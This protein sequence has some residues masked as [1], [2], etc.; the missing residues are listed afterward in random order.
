M[1]NVLISGISGQVGSYLAEYLLSLGNINVIGMMRRLS[2]SGVERIDHILKNITLVQGDLTD[3]CS[4]DAIMKKYRPDYTF[5]LA[6]QSH[7]HVSWQQPELTANVTG[8]GVLRLL[9]A[10]RKYAPHTIFYQAS[11]S[12]MF[13]KVLETPQKE[14]TPFY[15]RSPYGCA[16]VFAFETVRVYRESYNMM[17]MNGIMFNSESPR[18]SDEFVTRKITKAAVNIKAG[19]QTFL[20][21][22]NVDAKRDW[23]HVKDAVRAIWLI[24]NQGHAPHLLKDYLFSSGE[25]HSIRE[26]L[27]VAFSYIGLDWHQYV[28]VDP[29]FV[30]PAEVDLLLGDPSAIK[31]DLGWKS[32]IG[33]EM[34][35]HDMMN[36]D[37]SLTMDG[38]TSKDL[39]EKEYAKGKRT[40]EYAI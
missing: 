4:L 35:V 15:P 1:K 16:K 10:A 21:L 30:R 40:I 31:A 24:A 8:L 9:E 12:E 2:H 14:T 28:V 33:F 23:M 18:R 19:N 26:F 7:V 25:T 11:S 5:N 17:A 3:Q 29:T 20:K 37:I 34:L 13:G 32:E 39:R 22:G 38:M 36:N 27:D 6:A